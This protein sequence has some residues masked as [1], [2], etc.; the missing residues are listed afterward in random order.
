MINIEYLRGERESTVVASNGEVNWIPPVKITSSCKMDKEK[1]DK[2]NCELKFGSWTY[3][4]YK[5]NLKMVREW[6]IDFPLF[7]LSSQL[8]VHLILILFNI[9]VQGRGRCLLKRSVRFKMFYWHEH[10]H[11]SR[12]TGN[13]VP[14]V[15][16]SLSLLH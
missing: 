3:N 14:D 1:I 5:V 13:D 4:G 8:W 16:T 15:S 6:N 2:A 10:L 11:C 9:A 7:I 12:S